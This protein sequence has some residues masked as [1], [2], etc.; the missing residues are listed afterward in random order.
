MFLKEMFR[1]DIKYYLLHPISVFLFKSFTLRIFGVL[2]TY[3][4]KKIKHSN[5]P[6]RTKLVK[7]THY[8]LKSLLPSGTSPRASIIAIWD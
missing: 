3:Y 8:N 4:P 6:L 1:K 5:P 2:L 7:I